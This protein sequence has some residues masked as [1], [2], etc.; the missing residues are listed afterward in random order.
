MRDYMDLN[1]SEKAF[2]AASILVHAKDM[3][4]AE[5]EARRKNGI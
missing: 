3:E 2:V 1:D 4:N 5:K